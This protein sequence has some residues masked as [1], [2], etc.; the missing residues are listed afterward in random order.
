ML[1]EAYDLTTVF[2]CVKF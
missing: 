1:N 2:L